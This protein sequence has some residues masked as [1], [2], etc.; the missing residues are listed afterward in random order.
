VIT[1]SCIFIRRCISIFL[2]VHSGMSYHHP[3]LFRQSKICKIESSHKTYSKAKNWY[4]L[5]SFIKKNT[6]MGFFNIFIRILGILLS[7]K[8]STDPCYDLYDVSSLNPYISLL[9]CTHIHY[10]FQSIN[11]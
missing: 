8:E 1:D 11:V 6:R 7:T 9:I 5:F 10:K 3:F 4:L 2:T